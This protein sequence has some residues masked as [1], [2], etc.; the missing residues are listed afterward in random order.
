[1][2]KELA[3]SVAKATVPTCEE[4]SCQGN[5]Q[6]N[7]RKCPREREDSW[8]GGRRKP[9]VGDEG[10]L[11]KERPGKRKCSTEPVQHLKLQRQQGK[12]PREWEEVKDSLAVG[13]RR[14]PAVGN[15]GRP[16]EERETRIAEERLL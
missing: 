2:C 9:A 14:K 13:G 5:R 1:M 4:F 7:R 8:E 16:A 10:K 11:N 15:E 6:G 3:P 12:C